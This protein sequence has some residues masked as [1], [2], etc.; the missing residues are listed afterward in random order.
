MSFF[1]TVDIM[2]SYPNTLGLLASSLLINDDAQLN[3]TP[4]IRFVVQDLK[5]YMRMRSEV[6]GQRVLPIGYNA[7]TSGARDMKILD[8]LSPG[9]WSSSID[10]WT[11][12]GSIYE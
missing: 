11:A 3:V 10:F 6:V 8:C 4:V 2:A 7:A 12:S 1:R 9:D 5:K